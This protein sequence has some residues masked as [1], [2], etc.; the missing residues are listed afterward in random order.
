MSS[1]TTGVEAGLLLGWA[2]SS[3]KGKSRRGGPCAFVSQ[4]PGGAGNAV[5]PIEGHWAPSPAVA[6]GAEGPAG[7]T[8]LSPWPGQLSPMARSALVESVPATWSVAER[9]SD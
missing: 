7:L 4:L 3:S 8:S 2:M 1:I 5:G 9:R 6:W